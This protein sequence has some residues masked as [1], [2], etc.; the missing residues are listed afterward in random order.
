MKRD[1]LLDSKCD[2]VSHFFTFYQPSVE[3]YIACHTYSYNDACHIMI[4]QF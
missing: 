4:Y 1:F 2:L 3:N